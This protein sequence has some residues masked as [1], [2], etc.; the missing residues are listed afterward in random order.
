MVDQKNRKPFKQKHM[1]LQKTPKN[2]LMCINGLFKEMANMESKEARIYSVGFLP[3]KPFI[4]LPSGG[5]EQRDL[6]QITALSPTQEVQVEYRKNANPILFKVT[7]EEEAKM[8][9]MWLD[10]NVDDLTPEQ[11][12]N[13]YADLAIAVGGGSGYGCD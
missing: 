2:F 4:C 11:F 10:N 1:S 8:F 9:V 3:K 12:G 6:L 13:H 5:M 7:N